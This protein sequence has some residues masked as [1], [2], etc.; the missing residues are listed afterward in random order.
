MARLGDTRYGAQ[1]GDWGSTDGRLVGANLL[2]EPPRAAVGR[3]RREDRGPHGVR[4]LSQ[5]DH[6]VATEV[7]RAALQHHALAEMPKGGHV[8]A[9]EPQLFV[10]DVRA[11]FREVR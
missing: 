1:G 5:G 9:F 11:F 7:A 4:G 10:D 2:R 8:A 6:L 3:G